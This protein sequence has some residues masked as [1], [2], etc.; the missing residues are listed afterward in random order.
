MAVSG[1]SAGNPQ[2]LRDIVTVLPVERLPVLLAA[3]YLLWRRRWTL[4]ST[5]LACGV[6]AGLYLLLGTRIYS[7]TASVMI[8]QNAPKAFSESSGLAPVSETFNLRTASG[9][10]VTVTT[11]TVQV[12][13]TPTPSTGPTTGKGL[14]HIPGAP[15]VVTT[16]AAFMTTRTKAFCRSAAPTA[17]ATSRSMFCGSTSGT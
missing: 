11:K 6:A 12:A 2:S 4:L 10:D 1:F 14:D 9:Q 5:V 16:N 13:D 15:E 3:A 7:A 8:Q 17:N